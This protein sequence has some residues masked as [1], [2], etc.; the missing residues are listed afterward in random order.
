MQKVAMEVKILDSVLCHIKRKNRILTSVHKIQCPRHMASQELLELRKLDYCLEYQL[1][2]QINVN[3]GVRLSYSSLFKGD[4]SAEKHGKNILIVGEAGTGKSVLCTRITEDWANGKLFKDFFI[5]FLLPLN[6]RSVASAKNLTELLLNLYAFDSKTC[7]NIQMYLTQN[8]KDNIL[9][10]AD[11]WDQLC[12]SESQQDSFLHSLLF[13][14]LLPSSTFTVLVTTTPT[15]V[16]QQ[17][18]G[19]CIA[20]Q[21]LSEE[22][23]KSYIQ[24][25]LSESPEKL[26]Y[27]TEQLD[28]NPLVRSMCSVPLNLALICNYCQSCDDLLPST[29]PELYSKLAW[30]LARLKINETEQYGKISNYR[31]LPDKLQQSWSH[32]CQLSFE[33]CQ[34]GISQ[35]VHVASTFLSSELEIFGLLKPGTM[36]RDEV[37]LSFLLPAFK[38]YLAISHLMTQP[39]NVQLE[40]IQRMDHIDPMFWRFY[41]YRNASYDVISEFVQSV[42]KMHHSC[43]DMCLFSYELKNEIVNQ[44]IVKSIH[45]QASGT[46][47]ILHS[48]NAYECAAMVHVLEKMDQQCTVEINFQ[49]CTLKAMQILKLANILNNQSKLKGLI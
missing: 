24:M 9:I 19:R 35:V 8:Q 32:M 38:Y 16:P 28:T 34:A 22:S 45:Y 29:M 23:M 2:L 1:S 31:D 17:F 18:K 10:I 36:G 30:N 6:Q 13:G 25:E 49:N 40:M 3:G 26:S 46:P 41:L 42:S 14:N 11:G 20:L 48:L 12:E 47:I 27:I 5:V 44:A 21:G 39:Q 37:L 4:H 15:S 7:S 43:K 33:N